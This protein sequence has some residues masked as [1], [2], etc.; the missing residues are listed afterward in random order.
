VLADKK[1]GIEKDAKFIK[2]AEL[3]N[4]INSADILI[5]DSDPN[6]AGEG[7]DQGA[8][9]EE[10]YQN[11][12]NEYIG[13]ESTPVKEEDNKIPKKDTV[14]KAPIKKDD[15][16]TIGSKVEEPKKKKGL[17]KRL[18]EKKEKNN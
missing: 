18:F 4:E 10:D 5:S 15:D 6:P 12:N 17:L 9:T 7:E 8:G 13:P 16:N 1:L 11:G 2:P 14:T 3:E